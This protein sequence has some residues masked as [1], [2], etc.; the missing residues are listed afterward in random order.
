ML[1]YIA[2]ICLCTGII[3]SCQSQE[4]I[5]KTEISQAQ[6]TEAELPHDAA[7]RY[8][9]RNGT[10]FRLEGNN[11]SQHLEN[12]KSFQALQSE[13]RFSDI[14]IAFIAAYHSAFKLLRPSEELKVISFNVEGSG[15]KHIRLN[16]IFDGIPVRAS[17]IIVHL[18]RANQVCLVEG[19][20]IP[21]PSGLPT[22]PMIAEKEAL[23]K[24]GDDLKQEDCPGCRPELIVFSDASAKPYLAYRVIVNPG[25]AQGWEYFIDAQTGNIL[26]KLSTIRN[27]GSGKL[28]FK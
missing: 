22:R 13:N 26:A 11:L 20:Y 5:K 15:Q 7:V 6:K 4:M 23:R 28:K 2:V 9:E 1:K 8:D 10:I 3:V 18:N 12:N 24:I 21:T 16:Q 25:M 27:M 14:A 17:E 19:R